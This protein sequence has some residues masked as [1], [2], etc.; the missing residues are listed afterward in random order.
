[1][2]IPSPL[3]TRRHFLRTSSVLLALPWLESLAGAAEAAAPPRRMVNVC[4]SFGLYGPSFFPE[5]AGRDYV[6]S[7]YL[8]GLSA[9]RDRYTVFSGISHPEIGGDHASEACF[10]T[11][12]KRPTVAGFRNTVS[13]DYLAAK[14]VG[15]ATRFPLLSLS[16]QDG[17]TALT[18]TATGAGVPA[19][20]KPSDIFARLFLAGSEKD[21]AKEMARLKR[22][23]SVLDR[24]GDRFA[25][26]KPRLSSRDRQQ[27]TDYADAVR[28]M[29][30]QLQANEAWVT[31]PKPV[32]AEPAPPDNLERSDNVGRARLLFNLTRLALQTDSTRVVTIFI[33][34]MDLKPPIEGVTEDHHGLSHH[35]RNPAKIEQL[36]KIELA[37]MAAFRDFL[38]S[39]QET[40]EAAGSL[41]DSTQVL[42]GSNLGDASG[43]GTSN[44]PIL[45]A[46]GGWKHGRHIAGD[47]QSNTPLGKLFVSMLQRF[48]VETDRFGSGVGTIDGLV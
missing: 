36:R 13:L 39:L 40:K 17:G 23:Q 35:G 45:L 24:M 48:G 28:D 4:T 7:E 20:N 11:S 37:E 44:L 47:P 27:V 10:L 8:Q 22:G 9:L 29:E 26:L 21:V 12:A 19:L 6:P 1:M 41:L 43:H 18:Y 34:G 25:T 5:N 46:G 33:R 14:Q 16:T 38:A 15:A 3:Q 2:N 31:R 32:V 42:L 30:L